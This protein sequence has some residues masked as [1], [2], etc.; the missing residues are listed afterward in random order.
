MKCEML[1]IAWKREE[2]EREMGDT[3]QREEEERQGRGV[4]EREEKRVKE[5]AKK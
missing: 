1:Y 5:R 3:L 4:R 2:K